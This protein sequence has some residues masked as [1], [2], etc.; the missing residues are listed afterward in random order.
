MPSHPTINPRLFSADAAA[1]FL[2]RPRHLYD[3]YELN[4][5]RMQYNHCVIK[6]VNL[7]LTFRNQY[8]NLLNDLVES[9]VY[10]E[11]HIL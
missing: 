11:M 5:E 1:T 2:L 10:V 7:F 8:K 4:S 6:D 3:L 9:H